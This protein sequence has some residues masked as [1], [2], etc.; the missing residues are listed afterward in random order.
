MDKKIDEQIEKQE[1]KSSLGII[2]DD[3]NSLAKRLSDLEIFVHT[4][5]SDTEQIKVTQDKEP[6][7][8]EE[9]ITNAV[10]NAVEASVPKVAVVQ[11]KSKSFQPISRRSIFDRIRGRR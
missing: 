9:H 1:S 10:N 5:S 6:K 3:L 11:P 4:V 8:I 7:V 2:R